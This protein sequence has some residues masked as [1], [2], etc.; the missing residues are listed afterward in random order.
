MLCWL[1]LPEEGGCSGS[2]RRPL[3][4]GCKFTSL[5]SVL[6]PQDLCSSPLWTSNEFLSQGSIAK[7]TSNPKIKSGR[8]VGSHSWRN[9]WE[10]NN[11]LFV[12]H[13]KGYINNSLSLK[14]GKSNF[15]FLVDIWHFKDSQYT[16]RYRRAVAKY[17]NLGQE[18]KFTLISMRSGSRTFCIKL[19][20][21]SS[22]CLS[23]SI[24]YY[25]NC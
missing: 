15:F 11:F 6:C 2:P 19:S 12:S 9:N 1:S 18:W 17:S 4:P 8:A 20:F 14:S 13:W 21:F 7:R 25:L 22:L 3:V 16:C 10:C 23:L 5:L 24:W